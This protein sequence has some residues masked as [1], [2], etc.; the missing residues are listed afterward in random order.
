MST[1]LLQ[2]NTKILLLWLPVVLLLSSGIFYIMLNK[3]AHHAEEKY[4]LLKQQNVWNKFTS[5][6]GALEK[7]IT[8]E[9]TIT[10][11]DRL[12]SIP[13]NISRD[14]MIFYPDQKKALPFRLLTNRYQWQGHSY[15]ISTYISSTETSHLITKVFVTEGIILLIL[16]ITISVLSRKSSGKLWSPFFSSIDAA[17]RFDITR[18]NELH[19]PTSTGT[20]EFDR[21]NVMLNK[22]LEHVN[23]AY[24]NQKQFV[25][26][27]SHEIQTPLAIIRTKLELLINQ[28]NITEKEA[29]LLGDI[30][31]AT[32]RLSEMNKTLLLL[33]KI[34]NKQFPDTER[35]NINEIVKE[36]TEDCINY[37]DECPE[38]ES[39]FIQEVSVIA[40]RSLIEI[41]ISNLINNAIVHNNTEG[42]ITLRIENNRFIIK[43][44][45]EPLQVSS[46]ILFDRFKK[47]NH[48]KKTTGLGLAL[49]KQISQLYLY[50][51]EYN[52]K[53]GWHSVEVT[54]NV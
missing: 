42:K 32:N 29:A 16:L 37:I 23:T 33:A 10:R 26:N 39:N 21:L 38:I 7:Q 24:V 19:L 50:K 53:N 28:P 49:V 45:G 4:L 6:S 41:L 36:I 31:N 35:V 18:N 13:L 8:G 2:R 11:N 17:E 22:L 43:N 9:Y 25:E 27:A 30:A 20:T 44:T 34:E 12:V 54:F 46:E 51:I 47:N 3:H 48:Q 1:P 52:Y 14:T 40:N 5:T 15:L